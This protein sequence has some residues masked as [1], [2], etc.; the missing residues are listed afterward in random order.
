MVS[1]LWILAMLP[2]STNASTG[3]WKPEGRADRQ[4]CLWH[5]VPLQFFD[6]CISVYIRGYIFLC[7]LCVSAVSVF[8]ALKRLNG[9]R[10]GHTTVFYRVGNNQLFSMQV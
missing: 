6:P 7:A 3:K 9:A 4:I 8:F 1:Y 2:F 10:E 5:N